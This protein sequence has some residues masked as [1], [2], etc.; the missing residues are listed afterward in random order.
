M[1]FAKRV[2]TNEPAMSL[3]FFTTL[4]AAVASVLQQFGVYDLTPGQA[5]AVLALVSALA[6]V[7]SFAVRALVK[8]MAKINQ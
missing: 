4:L 1:A 6:P 3:G 5:A 8:P 2:L 7:A